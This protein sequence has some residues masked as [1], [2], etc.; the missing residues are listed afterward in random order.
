MKPF[1]KG[2]ILYDSIY[3]TVSKWQSYNNRQQISGCQGLE[4]QGERDY[5]GHGD[6]FGC[7]E[8]ALYPDYVGSCMNL[9]IC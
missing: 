5:K 6:V 7:D 9:Y 2:Y 3:M 1:L 4:V 8:T